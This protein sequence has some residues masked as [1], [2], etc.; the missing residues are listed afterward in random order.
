M[1]RLPELLAQEVRG[2]A[3]TIPSVFLKST[4]DAITGIPNESHVTVKYGVLTD[5]AEEVAAVIAGSEPLKITLGRMWVFHNPDA[6]VIKIRVESPSLRELHNRICQGT[7]TVNTYR[8]YRGHV[9]VAYMVHRQE[10]P[11]YYRDFLSDQFEGMEFEAD[12]VVFSATNGQK[13]IISFD[14][15]VLPLET[16]RAA[17]VAKNDKETG[18][19]KQAAELVAMAKELV[20]IP[21]TVDMPTMETKRQSRR[22]LMLALNVNESWKQIYEMFMTFQEGSS[23]KMHYFGV[24]KDR[25]SG[26][27]VGGNAYGRIGYTPKAIEVARG[28][29]GMVMGATSGKAYDKRRKGYEPIEV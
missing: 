9:T 7:K 16:A 6:A 25:A 26:Q 1:V 17:R 24:F 22:A 28:S 13:S 19:K 27:C 23:N 21:M 2:Y 4:E 5:D 18:M 14:G 8:D 12:Q 15:T 11:Y 3:A 20:A 29:E 10:D